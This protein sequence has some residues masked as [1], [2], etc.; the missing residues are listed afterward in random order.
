MNTFCNIFKLDAQ[1]LRL[2]YPQKKSIVCYSILVL[3]L[4]LQIRAL[5][6]CPLWVG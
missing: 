4:I 1:W 6:K 5:K 2:T 3:I